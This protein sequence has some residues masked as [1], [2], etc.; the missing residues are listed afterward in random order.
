MPETTKGHDWQPLPILPRSDLH[1]SDVPRAA[2]A[3]AEAVRDIDKA[4]HRQVVVIAPKLGDRLQ[5][6]K[7]ALEQAVVMGA[8]AAAHETER[9][10][11]ANEQAVRHFFD[12]AWD[13][14][15]TN[16]LAGRVAGAIELGNK[17]HRTAHSALDAYRWIIPKGGWR[18]GGKGIWTAGHNF[19]YLWLEF[20]VKC[21]ENGLI[22]AWS[23]ASNGDGMD[24]WL[25][26]TVDV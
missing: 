12:A 2:S 18:A 21:T 19:H 1:L 24:N 23:D 15:S 25:V 10:R 9:Q 20:L 22:P 4:T 13:K 5:H 7:E 6:N 3:V 26:L 16:I 8:V 17:T 14:F 11:L